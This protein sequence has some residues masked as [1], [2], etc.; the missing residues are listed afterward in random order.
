MTSPIDDLGWLMEEPYYLRPQDIAKLT[1]AQIV[2][3][4][5]RERDSKT[6]APKPVGPDERR[7][8]RTPEE[9]KE[10]GL[11]V[12]TML[13][14]SREKALAAMEKAKIKKGSM[15]VG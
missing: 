10:Q 14:G 4:Y 15:P 8:F 1:D 3:L 9:A 6:G 7:K 2:G 13:L 12:L 11:N 5:G